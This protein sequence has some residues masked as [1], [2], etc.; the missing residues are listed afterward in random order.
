[1]K[2]KHVS[3]LKY[4]V[5]EAHAAVRIEPGMMRPQ[6]GKVTLQ[7][8]ND[9]PYKFLDVEWVQL[10]MTEFG[11]HAPLRRSVGGAM[12]L[13]IQVS[14]PCYGEVPWALYSMDA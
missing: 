9:R 4:R 5:N 13:G 12:P 2:Q 10:L 14:D 8:R 6:R 11:T 3:T 1:M 7:C